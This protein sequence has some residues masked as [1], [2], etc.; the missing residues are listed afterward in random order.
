MGVDKKQFFKENP[1]HDIINGVGAVLSFSDGVIKITG[2]KGSGKSVL[3]QMLAQELINEKLKVVLFET[4]PASRQELE[5]TIC[6]QLD[7]EWNDNF[8]TLL[9]NY[10]LERPL[11]QQKIVLIFDD[12]D[13]LNEEC[14]D[15]IRKIFEIQHDNHPLASMIF[16]GTENLED[17]LNRPENIS[18]N[19]SII[20]NF[21]LKPM[22]RKE[23]EAFCQHFLIQAGLENH[24][25]T[26][27]DLDL[28]FEE[29]EGYPEHIVEK[30]YTIVDQDTG[31]SQ[32]EAI[33]PEAVEKHQAI[34]PEAAHA[35][36]HEDMPETPAEHWDEDEEDEEETL[37]F[38]RIPLPGKWQTIAIA[39]CLI[40]L[41]AAGGLFFMKPPS[42]ANTNI[43][44]NTTPAAVPA[45]NTTVSPADSTS[46]V[47]QTDDSATDI[48]DEIEETLTETSEEVEEAIEETIAASDEEA[49]ADTIATDS[50]NSIE[51]EVE[52]ALVEEAM[53]L[54]DQV[55]GTTD[56]ADSID[57]DDPA[58]VTS[59]ATNDS[60]IALL[61]PPD[62]SQAA[63]DSAARTEEQSTES[64]TQTVTET[65][66]S[67]MDVADTSEGMA[68]EEDAETM[69]S[70]DTASPSYPTNSSYSTRNIQPAVNFRER[71][72][73][74][75]SLAGN[76]SDPSISSE[77][78]NFIGDWLSAW[79]SQDVE[80]Y[81]AHYHQQFSS[82][83]H[84]SVNDWRKERI[85]RIINPQFIEIEYDG[86]EYLGEDNNGAR[87]RLWL[88][89][90]SSFYLDRTLKEL[91]LAEAGPGQLSIIEEKNL[92]VEVIPFYPR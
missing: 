75:L 6:K 68:N 63:N 77:M 69:A 12:S 87:V 47:E 39:A 86:I 53:T 24:H 19:K 11:D 50:I 18:I 1:Y 10:I 29:T 92:E 21:E 55:S 26:E 89:Y 34:E 42:G 73:Q 81:F 64:L 71:I 57:T 16:C 27:E 14:M 17:V 5:E 30:I 45:E 79:K 51:T 4:A 9:V 52:E 91:V 38:G 80:Q 3:C 82:E 72:G 20:L 36:Q 62:T 2:K 84:A 31:E 85:E 40:V 67:S 7:L 48:L 25:L 43:A 88:S 61:T 56:S 49:P 28:I 76:E 60:R 8:Q 54:A 58:S 22:N 65:E 66:P 32:A 15:A 70:T 41:V 46:L 74:V 23:L 59:E 37:L 83:Q 13:N 33:L 90:A 78:K 35:D 44:A